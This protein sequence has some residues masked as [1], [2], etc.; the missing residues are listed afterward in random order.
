MIV[1]RTEGKRTSPLNL[2]LRSDE[3]ALSHLEADVFLPKTLSF[4]LVALRLSHKTK[5]SISTTRRRD[6]GQLALT[7]VGLECSR[8]GLVSS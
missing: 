5:K 4:S 3:G 6:I 8:R 2:V 7:R 1:T